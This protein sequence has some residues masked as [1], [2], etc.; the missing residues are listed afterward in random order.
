MPRAPSITVYSDIICP[1]CF[2]GKRQLEAALATMPDEERPPLTW[3][4]FELNPNMPAEGIARVDY[5]AAKFGKAKSDELDAR[6]VDVG[7]AVGIV[8]NFEQQPRTPNSRRAHQLIWA[9]ERHDLQ[10]GVVEHLFSAYFEQG[11]D[12]SKDSVL[13]RIGNEVGLP[14]DEVEQAIRSEDVA[15]QVASL[16][17]TAAHIGVQGVPFFII[18]EK[19]ALSGAQPPEQWQSIFSELALLD[20][21][22][23][24]ASASNDNAPDVTEH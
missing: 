19:Y 23:T 14:A 1:W 16:E 6:L 18:A 3:R 17:Q 13:K 20:A 7:R 5:R 10:D 22:P 4:P 2:V 8:F 15:K 24:P 9:A 11:E 21:E 12:I